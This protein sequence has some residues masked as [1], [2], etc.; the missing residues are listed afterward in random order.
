MV[1]SVMSPENVGIPLHALY[2]ARA[3]LL[4][5]FVMGS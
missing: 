2:L 1:E 3:K 4:G 5:D